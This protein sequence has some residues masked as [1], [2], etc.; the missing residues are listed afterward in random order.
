[1]EVIKVNPQPPGRPVMKEGP[2]NGESE[3]RGPCCTSTPSGRR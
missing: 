3:A 1:M 2:G